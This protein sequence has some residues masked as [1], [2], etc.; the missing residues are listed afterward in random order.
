[1]RL[2]AAPIR[3]AP[4]LEPA[5]W[6]IG[7]AVTMQLQYA[8]VA[9]GATLAVVQLPTYVSEDEL[10]IINDQDGVVGMLEPPAV[11][12]TWYGADAGDHLYVAGIDGSLWRRG[13]STA[14]SQ[15]GQVPGALAWDAA[16][17]VVAITDDA[18]EVSSDAGQ[19]FRRRTIAG[20]SALREVR[21]RL[22]GVIVVRD[23]EDHIWVSGDGGQHFGRARVDGSLSRSGQ[24][25]QVDGPQILALAANG[26]DWLPFVWPELVPWGTLLSEDHPVGA[27][28]TVSVPAAPLAAARG[29]ASVHDVDVEAPRLNIPLPGRTFEVRIGPRPMGVANLQASPP[30]SSSRSVMALFDGLCQGA[31]R[32]GGACQ[33]YRRLPHLLLR[34]PFARQVHIFAWPAECLAPGRAVAVKGAGLLTCPGGRGGSVIATLGRDGVHLEA[35]AVALLA[36]FSVGGA[37]DG[38]M[39]LASAH[40][41]LVRRPLALGAADAWY[42]VA[43][44]NV[45]RA[46]PLPGGQVL[47]VSHRDDPTHA[48]LSLATADGQLHG[49]VSDLAVEA[50]VD[51]VSVDAVTG[52]VIISMRGSRFVVL[53]DGS[54]RDLTP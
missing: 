35:Q 25:I 18:V 11:K 42:Q 13:R 3:P 31:T 51:D 20:A 33:Q 46:I 24:L 38:T 15:V 50:P 22:D 40:V 12:A 16:R 44:A 43:G 5:S 10:V 9:V 45:D 48:Q 23:N 47:I 41:V 2:Y 27:H 14:F 52:E 32:A 28:V 17:L 8:T 7:L 34:D 53:T 26:R 4:W 30:P 6:P 37:S 29:A 39:S 19:S 49:L 36:G 54:L 21:T 1:L